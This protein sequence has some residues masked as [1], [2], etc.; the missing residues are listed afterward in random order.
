[1]REVADL[2]PVHLGSSVNTVVL[3]SADVGVGVVLVVK[4][5]TCLLM[6]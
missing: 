3:P 6:G 5:R 4:A 2:F 1:M